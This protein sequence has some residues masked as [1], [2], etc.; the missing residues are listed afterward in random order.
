MLIKMG[1]TENLHHPLENIYTN[2]QLFRTLTENTDVAILM[3]GDGKVLY[4]NPAF[5]CIS[6]YT[7]EDIRNGEGLNAIHPEQRID[8]AGC[9]NKATAGKQVPENYELHF[10]A[11]SGEERWAELSLT[12]VHYENQPAGIVT[13]IDITKRKTAE[14]KVK[15]SESELRNILDNLQDTYYRTDLQGRILRASKSVY[16]LL[17]YQ[18]EELLG[19]K[20]ADLYVDPEGREKFLHLM[21]QNNGTVRNYEAALHRKDGSH[22][23]VST[24][25]HFY[26]DI[27][28]NIQGVEGTTRDISE[29][30]HTREEL[31]KHHL[32]LEDLITERTLDLEAAN[33]EL[34]SF[35]Y[36]VSHDLRSPLRSIDGF[37]QILL[38]DY[39]P[40]LDDISKN[41]LQRVRSGAQRMGQLIDDLLKLSRVSSGGLIKQTI[42]LSQLARE[43]ATELRHSDPRRD[44][45]ITIQPGL[46]C[47]ADKGLMRVVMENLFSNAWKYT[48]YKQEQAQI[49]FS[50]TNHDEKESSVFYIK[51]NGAGFDMDYSHKLFTPFQRLH[52]A[53]EFE[54]SG[55]GLATVDRIIQR[56]GGKVWAEGEPDKG[57]TFYFSLPGNPDER[58]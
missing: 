57:A 31:E 23:W 4:V 28:A 7:L 39:S 12:L 9:I 54:G 17:G 29:I 40:I 34:E 45:A 35:C 5:E 8:F 18:E 46:N 53:R 26:F 14:Q 20:L 24:N 2:P 42:D 44:A 50:Q 58:C 22:V 15:H 56:H 37:S 3:Y 51:D 16:E 27:H 1:M 13:G 36:S 11:K 48:Q 41:Y 25:A 30:I 47:H 19:T 43:V 49:E 21:Q 38:E 52:P 10:Y 55:V 6:G 32:H 33:R